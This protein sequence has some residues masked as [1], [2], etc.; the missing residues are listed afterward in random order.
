[1]NDAERLCREPAMRWAVGDRTIAG[2]AATASQ[3]GR[4]ETSGSAGRKTVR[5]SR[6]SAW[7]GI[8][9][10][11]QQQPSKMIVLEMDSSESPTNGE[12]E[13]SAYYGHFGCTATI[14][15]PCSTNSVMSSDAP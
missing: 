11:H 1:V 15:C 8:G 12:Q 6:R 5:R 2:S 14:R 13:G 7:R 10:V 4:F 3:M 9:K